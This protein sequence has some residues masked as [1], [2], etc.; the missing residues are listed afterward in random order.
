MNKLKEIQESTNKIL[1]KA[2][3]SKAEL[4]GVNWGDL[5][6]VDVLECK[7]VYGE[8]SIMVCIEECSPDSN[9]ITFVYKELLSIYPGI[10]FDVRTEW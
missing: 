4:K 3:Q 7:S 5:D 9:L 8:T 6:C 2:F 1:C 10:S